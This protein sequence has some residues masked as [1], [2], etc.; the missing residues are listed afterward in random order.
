M[1]DRTCS[2]ED[3][4]KPLKARGLCGTCWYQARKAGMPLIYEYKGRR[5]IAVTPLADRYWAKVIK[6]SIHTDDCW[7]WS[8][9]CDPNGYGRLGAERSRKVLLAHHV[10]WDIHFPDNP[11]TTLNI[12]HKCDNPPCTR[13]DHLFLGSQVENI[14]DMIKKGRGAKGIRHFNVKLLETDVRL[15]RT[16]YDAKVK[17]SDIAQ[18]FNVSAGTVTRIGKRQGWTHID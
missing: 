15:I 12:C 16:Q 9:Y 4:E 13:P 3:C 6:T 10:S 5:Q 17:R 14:Q 18:Q 11:R 1:S 8:G 7:G 2:V